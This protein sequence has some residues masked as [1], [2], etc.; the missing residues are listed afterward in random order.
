MES[1]KQMPGLP[2]TKYMDSL[3][4]FPEEKRLTKKQG[5]PSE[6]P[7]LTTKL[8]MSIHQKQMANLSEEEKSEK[9]LSIDKLHLEYKGIPKIENL[10]LFSSLTHLY[11][12]GVFFFFVKI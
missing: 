12:Q 8:I 5:S 1:S 10:E 2:G 3:V 6:A 7:C 11:L 4:D 9:L